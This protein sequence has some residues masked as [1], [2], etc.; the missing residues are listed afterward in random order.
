MK[1]MLNVFLTG[2]LLIGVWGCAHDSVLPVHDEVLVFPLPY[3]LAFLRTLEA[4]QKHPDWDL[5]RTDKENGIIIIRNMRFSSYADAD[6]RVA[7]ILVKRT[8]SRETSIE[9]DKK[10]QAVV[11]G[12]EI[13][14][15]IR[16]NLSREVSLR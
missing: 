2:L 1:K 7:T 15:L 5:D 3:D 9:F 8:D 12:D 14:A 13:L 6:Q 4:I 16:Q 11:G 10:S